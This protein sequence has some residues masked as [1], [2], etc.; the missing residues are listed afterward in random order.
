MLLIEAG[1]DPAH[2]KST[3]YPEA[4]PGEVYSCPGYHAAATEDP[5]V[6]WQ[7]SVRHYSDTQ[8]QQKDEKYNKLNADKRFLD[9]ESQG[10]RGKGGILYPRSASLGGCTSHHAMIVAVP[11]DRDWDYIADL[12]GDESWRASNMRGYFARLER[13]L[14][15]RDY[16]KWFQRLLGPIYYL[17][18]W[19]VLLFDPKAVLDEGGH[20]SKGWQ[21]TSFIDPTLIEGIQKTDRDFVSLLMKSALAVLHSDNRLVGMLKRSL[22]ALRIVQHIDPNDSNTRRTSPEG[23][24]LI[25]TG[26]DAEDSPDRPDVRVKGRRAG[27]REFVLKTRDEY[28]DRL[29]IKMR[30]HVTR[31][32]FEE[33]ETDSEP[34]AIGIEAAEGVH[35]YEASPLQ[36]APP[37]ARVR[38]FARREVIL[39]GGAFNTPQLLNL[40]G[41]GNV[42]DLAK[43]TARNGDGARGDEECV[44][45]G[46]DGLPLRTEDGSARR[47]NLPGVGCNLQDRY[48]VSVISELDEEFATLRGATFTPG[49]ANDPVRTEW[50]NTGD[51]LYRTNGGTL[52]ILKRSKAL[53]ADWPEPDLFAF[54]APAAFRGYY[55]RWSQELLRR[56]LGAPT[57]QRNL[58]SWIILKAYTRNN[59]G[60]VTIRSSDP[61]AQ[62]EIC[63]DSFNE[64]AERDAAELGALAKPY[65]DSGEQL[66]ADLASRIADIER[67]RTDGKRDLLALMDAVEFIRD[68]NARNPQKFV[69]EIQ[70]GSHLANKSAEL[71]EWIRTQAWGHH[72]SCT[73]RMGSDTWQSDPSLLHDRSA[74]VDSR[75]RVHGVAGLRIVDASV[76]PRIPGYF[77]LTPIL[78][79]S[80]K[81]ADVVL[82]DCGDEVYVP[83]FRAK[84]TAA[85]EVRRARAHWHD[86]EAASDRGT[87]GLAIS[88]GGI[89]SAT[90]GLGLLQA[91]A[92]RDRL[93]DVD[94][95]STV[96][97][98]GFIGSF[99]GRLFTR[100]MVTESEDPVGRVQE[101]LTNARSGPLLWLRRQANYIFANGSVDLR[102]NLAVFWRN[103]LSVHVIAGTLLFATFSALACLAG[104]PISYPVQK[105]GIDL[106]PWW[107]MPATAL[108]LGVLPATIAYW[109]SPKAGSYRPYPYHALIA[110]VVMLSAA[111]WML[112]LPHGR[113]F[114][115]A[116]LLVVLLAWLWQDVARWGA[117]PDKEL[118]ALRKHF[119]QVSRRRPLTD[120]EKQELWRKEAA[121][122]QLLGTIVRNRMTRALG[123]TLTIFGW[124]LAFVVLDTFSYLFAKQPG[125]GAITTLMVAFAPALPVLRYVGTGALHQ[126]SAAGAKG[127]SLIRIAKL[128][129]IPLAIL[130]LFVIDVLAH[131]LLLD[132]PG[133]AHL[134]IPLSALFAVVLGRAFD[135]LNL[136]SL[137]ATYSSRLSRTFLG[138]SNP[139]RVFSA[140]NEDNQDVQ[141]AHSEDDLPHDKY[142]P[143]YHGGPLHLINVCV[144]ETIDAASE[145][146]IRE[147]KGIS[148]C[149]TPHGV[150]VGRR[151][152]AEWSSP[153]SLPRWQKLRRWLQGIDAD[154]ASGHR[155]TALKA[156]CTASDPNAFHVLKSKSSES[157]EVEPLSLATWTSISGAAFT[158]GTGRGTTLPLALFMGLTNIRL[159]YWWDSGILRSERPGRYP[160]PLWRKL[161]RLPAQV[162]GMQSMLFAEWWGL[163]RG[164][165]EW[166][167]YLSDGGH[168]EVTGLYEL[169]RRRVP[170]V[171]L[172]DGGE[173]PDY[174]FGDLA[175]LTQQVRLD[176]GADIEWCKSEPG[177]L[178]YDLPDWIQNW[179][180]DPSAI[181]PITGIQRSGS[182][183]AAF[184]RVRYAKG[185]DVCWIL[186]IKPSL[187]HG[188]SQDISNH[189][190]SSEAFPQDSTFDQVFDDKQWESYR[191][192]GQQIGLR[193]LQRRAR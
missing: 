112:Q 101:I 134:L 65:R 14:Y 80:E 177:R 38:Y 50:M 35:L 181:G 136:S 140:S 85:V 143:E 114:A 182:Y 127:S 110:W 20:G 8:R 146:E 132:Y 72:A 123:E 28:P 111:F 193:V 191:A 103:I 13:C 115:G 141:S 188:L 9:P 18:Q 11:N 187:G 78:M 43:A 161:K 147:R 25:P 47:I 179:I 22:L 173:D 70:P 186:M 113:P 46:H 54:G 119:R 49:D 144:N 137:R 99:L 152:F 53:P 86:V 87:V 60:K 155:R 159:G 176:F 122:R 172:S 175:Q 1:T 106:S 126:I 108:V 26:I 55:W 76:F 168:F 27:V 24:F 23:A 62:P 138:A 31:V 118:Q 121:T 63:F 83:T 79:I 6:S 131:R 15:V 125:N 82:E 33:K 59:S 154:D 169:L 93:R 162:F 171:I 74:V 107:W 57:D 84:E 75:F 145:R 29:V 17:W 148:M 89:R 67:I 44:L 139:A 116:A 94:F 189:A 4:K 16:K 66:P 135:F 77:I 100:D 36:V 58:W 128:I 149:V 174:T 151:H 158:T 184:A 91:I 2:E 61:F 71:E 34:R 157:A 45:H 68:V 81:A 160:L 98:G 12:T 185:S 165:G 95:L 37:S 48:E 73:C 183:P 170:F 92:E 52:A 105:F 64:K 120:A 96:S 10:A 129:A 69:R 88:G 156:I 32:L 19:I 130:L 51:G 117:A 56:T 167:W 133:E 124:L 21:P 104:W 190:A 41:I 192:L 30:T 164:P 90:F 153:D 142:H 178:P 39:C 40:S 42:Q 7:F 180:R 109:L 166:F 102:E 5:A 150:I 163:F 3:L 97:G